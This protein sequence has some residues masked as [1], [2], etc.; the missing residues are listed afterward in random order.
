MNEQRIYLTTSIPY[1]NA[2]PHL[3]HALEFVQADILA[4]HYRH[5]DRP[6]RLLSGTDDNALKNVTAARATG[7]EPAAFV[8]GNADAF[9]RLAGP[10][11]LSLDDFIRTSSDP[12]HRPG[13]EVIWRR[14]AAAGDFSKRTYRGRYCAGCEQ[15]YPES[16]LIEGRCPEHGTV[17]AEVDEE[18][19]FFALSR[20][21]ERIRT[22]IRS[23]EVIIEPEQRRNEILALIDAG[24]P[25]ISVSRP[26]ARSGG[27]GVGV[28]GDPD[29]VIY[30]WWDALANY[31]TSLGYAQ[32]ADDYRA[33]WRDSTDRIHVIGKGIVR[34]H[35]L[36][37]LGQLLSA[38][39]PL[40]TAIFVHDYLTTG[41]NKIAKSASAPPVDPEQLLQTYGQDAVRWWLAA[42]VTRV[43]D[44][45]YTD[46][47][48]IERHDADLANGL[49][50]LVNRTV[51]LIHRR[52][53]GTLPSLAPD[54]GPADVLHQ[55]WQLPGQVDIA[56]TRFDLRTAA[57]TS[58][59]SA[60]AVNRYLQVT[61]PWLLDDADPRLDQI[62]ATALSACRV[63]VDELTP[64][65]PAGAARLARQV[66][67]GPSVGAADPVF[68]RLTG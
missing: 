34:F 5:R 35:A 36:T 60:G 65:V 38:G 15:F 47:A 16:E 53:N 59:E 68:S 55:V 58:I 10:L 28:P 39:L 40:P 49:G 13:V 50:N 17:P 1:V 21:E 48:L 18:N 4:R 56:L 23:G 25:D 64:F 62:L 7:A 51:S 29:Q 54:P 41:G 14:C 45:D 11:G 26:A 12:R 27:W 19:W 32:D 30:V 43:G 46:R 52:R 61:Q 67:V 8:A 20:Y 44:T 22:A 63:V 33:W 24:L 57:G 42:G 2:R 31:V 6:V 37:W 3:G 66:G 9:E